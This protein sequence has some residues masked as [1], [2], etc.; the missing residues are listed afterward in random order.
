M[1]RAFGQADKAPST[2]SGLPFGFRPSGRGARQG[3]V[4]MPTT[5]DAL[6]AFLAHEATRVVKAFDD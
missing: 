6:A 1:T 5:A 2:R 3:I 4:A